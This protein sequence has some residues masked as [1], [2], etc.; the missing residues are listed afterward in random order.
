M[1]PVRLELFKDE[2]PYEEFIA[3]S[4]DDVEADRKL[5]HI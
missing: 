4:E 1:H 2:A 3:K 5:T